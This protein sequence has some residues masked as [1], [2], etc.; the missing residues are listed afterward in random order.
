MSSKNYTKFK[1]KKFVYFFKKY[2]LVKSLNGIYFFIVERIKSQNIELEHNYQTQLNGNTFFLIP[3][4]KGISCELKL[5]QIH[6]P[7]TSKLI[8]LHLKKGM[9]CIDI[10]SNIG[11][12]VSL[13]SNI[14]GDSG[15][16]YAI[17]PSPNTLNYL[18]KNVRNLKYN[19]VEIHT[20]VCGDVDGSTQFVISN[21]SNWCRVMDNNIMDQMYQD[22]ESLIELP[23]KKLDTFVAEQNISKVDFV[24]M[25]L[26][27][28][29][30]KVINGMNSVLKK[31]HPI[32]QMEVHEFVIGKRKLVSM[33]SN[34]EKID[35]HEAYIL[36]RELDMPY[37]ATIND[38]KKIL[39]ST[40][41]DKVNSNDVPNVFQLLLY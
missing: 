16:I 5:F 14:V 19:N 11:Y 33:L 20:F 39:L 7:V 41:I 13:E 30:I 28:Y 18:K 35:Y 3:N 15:K 24:R 34:M 31:F 26:E 9:Y 1:L 29:E 10:G 21:R 22:K 40:L 2:G 37:I 23:M 12:F 6:E 38:A 17:E 25:D 8:S 32:I 36:P 27:G 4:D